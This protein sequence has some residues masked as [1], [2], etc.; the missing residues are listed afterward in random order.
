M[1]IHRLTIENLTSLKGHHSIDF[2]VL[3]GDDDIFAITGPTGAGKSTILSAIGIVLYNS[4]NKQNVTPLELISQG[5]EY[6]RVTIDFSVGTINYQATWECRISQKNG[7]PLKN[8][9]L[10][11]RFFKNGELIDSNGE[12]ILGLSYAQFCKT[13][14]LN[15][16]QF[17][18]FLTSKY[19]DRREILE[20]L[21]DAKQISELGPLLNEK[22]K[23]SKAQLQLLVQTLETLE[24]QTPRSLDQLKSDTDQLKEQLV[25]QKTKQQQ[26]SLF[27]QDILDYIRLRKSILEQQQ[28]RNKL[29]TEVAG[30]IEQQNRLTLSL[31]EKKN[32]HQQFNDN[33]EIVRPKL[34]LAIEKHKERN[35]KWHSSLQ[36]QESIKKHD[37]L[38]INRGKNRNELVGKIEKD[39][40][41]LSQSPDFCYFDTNGQIIDLQIKKLKTTNELQKS[42]G[43]NL[44]L[45]LE[46]LGRQEKNKSRLESLFNQAKLQFFELTDHQF[47]PELLPQ[48]MQELENDELKLNSKLLQQ[49]A[50]KLKQ[51]E[52]QQ[53]I[54]TLSAKL[55]AIVQT[56]SEMI[57]MKEMAEKDLAT[58]KEC[59]ERIKKEQELA[60]LQMAIHLCVEQS[61]KEKQC[62]VCHHQWSELPLFQARSSSLSLTLT[63]DLEQKQEV[64]V[65][66][67][68]AISGLNQQ[69]LS[70]AENKKLHQMELQQ[71]EEELAEESRKIAPELTET[72][73]RSIKELETKKKSLNHLVTQIQ[74]WMP[75]L[76]HSQ[77]LIRERTS[78][79]EKLQQDIELQINETRLSI[80]Q[81]LNYVPH[82]PRELNLLLQ[83]YQEESEH[84]QR[85]TQTKKRLEA[86]QRLLAQ[87][88]LE[89]QRLASEKTL[90]QD[91]LKIVNQSIEQIEKQLDKNVPHPAEELEKQISIGKN[92]QQALNQANEQFLNVSKEVETKN[93]FIASI[94]EIIRVKELEK[95]PF[96]GRHLTCPENYRS[97]P[98]IASFLDK[99][100][101]L[102]LQN[103]HEVISSLELY[104]QT[105]LLPLLAE[106]VKSIELIS[107][108]FHQAVAS[109]QQAL[110][111]QE[112]IDQTHKEYMQAKDHFDRYSLLN[113]LIG[114]QEFRDF[115]LSIIERELIKCANIELKRICDGRYQL[116]QEASAKH[117]FEFYIIDHFAGA[118]ERKV[119][120][121]SGGE[122]FL[123]S[124]AMAM[125]LSEMTRGKIQIDSFFIDEGFGSLDEESLNDALETLLQI[126]NRGKR[127]GIISHVSGLNQRISSNIRIDRNEIGESS[128]QFIQQ[129]V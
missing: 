7:T 53:T 123:V 14:I 120:T 19:T 17:A 4:A 26:L 86:D 52:I 90:L 101:R 33:F 127:I 48:V 128:L 58:T 9:K 125:G 39:K 60:E 21:F 22:L 93:T 10:S 15:Q 61:Q 44:Q 49:N 28:R 30:L 25:E 118:Q 65:Q 2:D 79:I 71:R 41:E 117:K 104:H 100:E 110:Q 37:E 92:L 13:V 121:L 113:D 124:L 102:Y 11:H 116:K 3:L 97:L 122:T 99:A 45:Q 63:D 35:E 31:Q 38:L 40:R 16:G 72:L 36:I 106:Q 73:E 91:Q 83:S 24:Q 34:M 75:E 20:T 23:S 111:N 68:G 50:T 126:R 66:L 81:L 129:S 105:S 43:D 88:D 77:G 103:D 55:D 42:L 69:I 96:E 108:K 67:L 82:Y 12:E 119:T 107:E 78:K 1:R 51:S 29:Q 64:L 89:Y 57:T 32:S 59:I 46:E 5:A 109:Y 80:D 18:E 56:L 47:S 76:Q 74:S 95:Q 112:R 84:W 8:P 114:K 54:K 85:V 62:V 6:G 98:A 27:G 87:V 70:L 115:A 94:D